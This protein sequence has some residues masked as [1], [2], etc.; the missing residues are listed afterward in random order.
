M[1]SEFEG[2]GLKTAPGMTGYI[3]AAGLQAPVL[4]GKATLA[5]G[6]VQLQQ[7]RD[8]T[9]LASS[10]TEAAGPLKRVAASDLSRAVQAGETRGTILLVTG[11][12]GKSVQVLGAVR[13]SGAVAVVVP[14]DD[15][16]KEAWSSLGGKTRTPVGLAG[17]GAVRGGTTVVLHAAAPGEAAGGERW[18]C[19]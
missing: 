15:S 16:T 1:A 17:S 6:G 4:D 12:E 10:G 7:G 3:Q 19:R 18:R 5:G 13:R 14:E 8:F 11:T 9:L 2:Y